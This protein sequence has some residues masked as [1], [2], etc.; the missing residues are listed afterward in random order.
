MRR[1][2]SMAR[3]RTDQL[4]WRLAA[5]L[6]G[7]LLIGGAPIKGGAAVSSRPVRVIRQGRDWTL[8]LCPALRRAVSRR[9]PGYV[10]PRLADFAPEATEAQ[11]ASVKERPALPYF[12]QGD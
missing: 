8:I 9:F 7:W 5:L 1:R 2:P 11:R 10:V 6:A 12:C 4:A 3:R